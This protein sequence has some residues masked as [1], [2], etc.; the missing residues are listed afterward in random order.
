MAFDG[1]LGVAAEAVKKGVDGKRGQDVKI[2]ILLAIL[3]IIITLLVVFKLYR[4]IL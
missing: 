3:L 4:K 1:V 2:V